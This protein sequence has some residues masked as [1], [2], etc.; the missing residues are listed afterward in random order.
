M[1]KYLSA[2]VCDGGEGVRCGLCRAASRAGVAHSCFSVC[3]VFFLSKS[4]PLLLL[5]HWDALASVSWARSHQEGSS[6][7]QHHCI[8]SSFPDSSRLRMI[9]LK[10]IS[11]LGEQHISR[12]WISL[13]CSINGSRPLVLGDGAK[14]KSWSSLFCPALRNAQV[15]VFNP[16]GRNVLL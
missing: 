12:R 14:Q 4:S 13:F 11:H 2:P 9:F 7:A 3:S 5:E 15:H 6:F 1:G 16:L 10:E 8:S